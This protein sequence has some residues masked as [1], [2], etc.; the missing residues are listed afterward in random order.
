MPLY[1]HPLGDSPNPRTKTKCN[2]TFSFMFYLCNCDKALRHPFSL[3]GDQASDAL[4]DRGHSHYMACSHFLKIEDIHHTIHY[5]KMLFLLK[6]SQDLLILFKV[7]P[8]YLILLPII[9][10]RGL[11]VDM[12]GSGSWSMKTTLKMMTKTVMSRMTTMQTAR[13]MSSWEK[14][15]ANSYSLPSLE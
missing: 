12:L 3:P 2:Q 10:S 7:L 13:A 4:A 11:N 1:Q 8:L 5:V 6:N 15:E 14:K 9:W